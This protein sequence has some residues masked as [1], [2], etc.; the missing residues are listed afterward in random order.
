MVAFFIAMIASDFIN[1]TNAVFLFFPKAFSSVSYASW[2]LFFFILLILKFFLLFI[3][4]D[5]IKK[6]VSFRLKGWF[7]F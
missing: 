7:Q 2:G 6:L 3:F 1:I 4:A 5:L